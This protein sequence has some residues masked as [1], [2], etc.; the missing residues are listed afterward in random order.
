MDLDGETLVRESAPASPSG[1]LDGTNSRQ[2][3][4]DG[5]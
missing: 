3:E 2:A 5:L 1:S 4:T